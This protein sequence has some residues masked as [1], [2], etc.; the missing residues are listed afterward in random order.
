[1]RLL[2][3][4]SVLFLSLSGQAQHFYLF[5][6]TYTIGGTKQSNGSKGIYVYD[7]DAATGEIKPVSTADA[8]NPSY[9]ALAP[10]G[11]FLYAANETE[12]AKPGGVSA[13]AFDKKTGQLQFLDRQSSGG[14]G[15]C[16]VSVDAHRKWAMV[17]NYSGGS[18]AALPI[19]DD[20]SLAPLVEF[21][22]HNGTGPNA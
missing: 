16:Y 3:S 5:F 8:E 12:G 7:F 1:M 22:Q 19:K 4:L 21:I 17:A 18:L 9:L 20:G 2:L 15:P 13:F 6:G 10:S 14:D 11:D